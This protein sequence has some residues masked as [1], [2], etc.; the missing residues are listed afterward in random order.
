MKEKLEQ[1]TPGSEHLDQVCVLCE[2]PILETDEV[3]SCPRCHS[4][5]HVDCWKNKGGCAR[6]GCP[7]LAKAVVGE[8]PKG[9]GPPPPISKWYILGG[10][11]VIAAIILISVYWPKPPDPAM[12]RTKITVMG[13]AYLELNTAMSQ[14][15]DEFNEASEETYIDLQLLPAGGMDQKLVV[16]IAADDAPDIFAIDD[17]RFEYFVE[18]DV[19]LPLGEENGKPVYGIQHPAQLTKFVIWKT[20]EHPEK[21]KEVLQYL[22]ENIPPVDLEQL[23]EL[24]SVPIIPMMGF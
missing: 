1:I 12:G 10:V 8:K 11:L 23:R 15:V 9:D 3:V 2:E 14:I 17:E 24:Q 19:L 18:H 21:A 6:T 20:T 7:Q 22:V 4:V 13:E 5:H 16:L